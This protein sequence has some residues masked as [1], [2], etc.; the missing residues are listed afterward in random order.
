MNHIVKSFPLTKLAD[1]GPTTTT[2]C[3][4]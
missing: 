1:N 4:Y 2:V 3:W